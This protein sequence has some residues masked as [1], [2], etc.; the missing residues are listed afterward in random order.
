VAI[1]FGGRQ[2]HQGD[3]RTVNLHSLPS[4]KIEQAELRVV[5]QKRLNSLSMLSKLIRALAT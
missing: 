1:Q 4:L 5:L 3:I 2:D